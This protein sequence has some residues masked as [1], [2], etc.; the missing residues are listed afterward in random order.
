MKVFDWGAAGANHSLAKGARCVKLGDRYIFVD[1]LGRPICQDLDI[2]AI[3][4]QGQKM[5]GEHL[6]PSALRQANE[7]AG[8][9]SKARNNP[10]DDFEAEEIFNYQLFVQT[11]E[12]A[13][14]I[15]HGGLGG[16]ARHAAEGGKWSPRLKDGSGRY[17]TEKLIVFLP[18][19]N[20]TGMTS[21][22]FEFKGYAELEAFCKANNFPWTF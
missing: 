10:E 2:G 3:A 18:V 11:G 4:R 8:K 19:K 20:G 15:K 1:A 6:Q 22:C 5:P 13:N 7:K 16:S 14:M 12:M 21:S 9:P 17:D